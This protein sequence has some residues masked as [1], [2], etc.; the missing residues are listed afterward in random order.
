MA[1]ANKAKAKS[2]NELICVMDNM[3][4]LYW[5]SKPS[6][7]FLKSVGI[8]IFSVKVPKAPLSTKPVSA[9]KITMPA[10]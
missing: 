2:F 8:G 1:T 6:A 5:A 9:I 7:Q 4:F 3:A 10:D